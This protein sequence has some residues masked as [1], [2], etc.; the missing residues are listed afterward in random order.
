MSARSL[1]CYRLDIGS[2]AN[3]AF[4]KRHSLLIFGTTGA[5]RT[6]LAVAIATEHTFCVRSARYLSWAK[7]VET[8]PINPEDAVQDGIRVWPWR[9]SD[10]VVLD[11]VVKVIE[12]RAHTSPDHI[13]ADLGALPPDV[14]TS[15]AARQTIW[16]LGPD[17]SG[18]ITKLS[19]ALNVAPQEFCA[20][21]VVARPI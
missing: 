15:L 3:F 11:D 13:V 14:V 19:A 9:A 2:A 21:E 1:H 7:F 20:V 18:W 16:M 10:I 17:Q 4:N 5:G 6:S 12:G 8:A